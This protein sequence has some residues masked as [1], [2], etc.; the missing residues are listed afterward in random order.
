M[1]G[2][3]L[4]WRRT[5]TWLWDD[6]SVEVWI[7][8]NRDRET[9][10]QIILNGANDKMEYGETDVT[11]IGATTAVHVV[12]GDSWMVEMAIPFAGLGV[13]PP[14]PGDEWGISL[15]RARPPGKGFNAELIVWA[16]LKNEG[17][18]DLEN[19]GTMI[20]K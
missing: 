9:F 19:F 15:C 10:R 7:D 20:F 16:A 18:K 11:P 12:E 17:F 3:W 13:K 8:A 2:R 6:D 1:I 14:Q 5:I 4:P